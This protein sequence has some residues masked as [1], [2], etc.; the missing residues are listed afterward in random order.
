MLNSQKRI[1]T[2][3]VKEWFTRGCKLYSS[4]NSWVYQYYKHVHLH[5]HLVCTLSS[6]Q[7]ANTCFTY[8]LSLLIYIMCLYCSHKR[9]WGFDYICI[10]FYFYSQVVQVNKVFAYIV[11][12]DVGSLSLFVPVS[13][14]SCKQ[15]NAHIRIRIGL[16]GIYF[17]TIEKHYKHYANL[18]C[19][20]LCLL[21]VWLGKGGGAVKGLFIDLKAFVLH[22]IIIQNRVDYKLLVTT[23]EC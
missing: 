13:C 23:L 6:L 2:E 12:H 9:R 14:V 17:E 16:N 20:G 10:Y 1:K 19:H 18:V 7:L 4:L 8:T 21:A 22:L 5:L 11:H 15:N 3:S